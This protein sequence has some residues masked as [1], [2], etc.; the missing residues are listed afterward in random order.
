LQTERGTIAIVHVQ[1][2]ERA[3]DT[4]CKLVGEVLAFNGS[5]LRRCV[6]VW[7][8]LA[9]NRTASQHLTGIRWVA[10]FSDC[11]RG[12]SSIGLSVPYDRLSAV[13]GW[14]APIAFRAPLELCEWTEPNHGEN[15]GP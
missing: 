7:K 6:E 10:R 8:E 4:E 3:G 1:S 14:Q 9:N 5:R 13:A 11:I 12:H 2:I 15:R